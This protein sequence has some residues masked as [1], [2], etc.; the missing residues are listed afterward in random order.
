MSKEVLI[1]EIV[2]NTECSKK[3]AENIIK[4]FTLGVMNAL[5]KGEEV[6]LIGFGKFKVKDQKERQGRNPA[7]G[8]AM[9]IEAR[10][11][12]SFKAGAKLKEVVN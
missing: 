11:V 7:T 2:N 4:A 9:T 6:S 3:E 10:K 8:E 5:S 1:S 12:P